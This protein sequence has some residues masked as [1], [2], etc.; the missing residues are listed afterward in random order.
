MFGIG[1]GGF[2]IGSLI[3]TA[4]LA[5]VTGGASL[6][7]QTA[8]RQ[9]VSSIAQEVLQ[10]VG[11]QLGL[12][13]AAIDVAQGAFSAASGNLPGSIGSIGSAATGLASSLGLGAFEAGQIERQSNDIVR[14]LVENTLEKAR[15][16][17]RS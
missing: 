11:Q 6:A 12:P 5:A 14:D 3:S 8:L 16:G 10:Q 15:N 1:G 2:N 4:A 13:Q 9:V 17:G 7:V